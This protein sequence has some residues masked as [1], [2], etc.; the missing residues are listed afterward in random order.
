MIDPGKKVRAHTLGELK[1][2]GQKIAMITAYDATTA[3]WADRAGVDVILVGDSLARPALGLQRELELT[4]EIM[5]H[6][7]AAVSRGAKR[8]LRIGDMPFMTCKVSTELALAH[9]ARMIREGG[10]EAVKIEGGAEIAPTVRALVAAGIPVMAHVGLRPQSFH[11]QGGYRIQGRDAAGAAHLRH[12]AATLAE[13]GAF[14]LILEGMPS[15]LAREITAA[16]SIPTI[17][18]GAGPACD[19]QV[20]VISDVLQSTDGRTPKLARAYAKVM[21][22]AVGAIGEFAAEVRAGSFPAPEH[23]SDAG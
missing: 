8:A 13:A 1:A 4:L 7:A 6:H 15:P 17:G 14:A 10:M 20:L 22:T 11:T 12:E 9:C 19:G 5:L 3:L 2:A 16:L 21:Q 23:E 18:I